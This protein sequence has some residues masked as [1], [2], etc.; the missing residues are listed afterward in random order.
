[1]RWRSIVKAPMSAGLRT[2]IRNVAEEIRIQRW[3]RRS[4][5]KAASMARYPIKLNLG[6]GERPRRGSGWVNIDLTPGADLQ[7]DLREPFPFP[8]ESVTEIYAEHFLEHLSLPNLDD[9]AAW[10]LETNERRSPA[11]SLLRECRRVLVPGGILDIVVLD[12]EGIV[13]EYI[14]RRHTEGVASI[15]PDWWGPRWCDTAMHRVNYMFRQ[16]RQHLYL[17]DE[18]TLASL[19]KSL[20]FTDVRRRD[21]DRQKDAANH[22]IGSLCMIAIKPS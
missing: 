1:M 15:P 3:H 10:D 7:L 12:A 19:L 6:A 21:F 4:I 9:S 11:L 17:Y 20:N 5:R 2:A 13:S 14:R 8:N 22:E 18:Q 16:G